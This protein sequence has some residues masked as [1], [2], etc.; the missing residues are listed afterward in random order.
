[1]NNND[2]DDKNAA[3]DSSQQLHEDGQID[4]SVDE[5]EG[6]STTSSSSVYCDQPPWGAAAAASEWKCTT[7]TRSAVVVHSLHQQPPF[8]AGGRRPLL[9]PPVRWP[10][11]AKRKQHARRPFGP[12]SVGP[13]LITSF[14]LLALICLSSVLNSFSG[15][16]PSSGRRVGRQNGVGV[17]RERPPSVDEDEFGKKHSQLIAT[18]AEA[19][20]AQRMHTLHHL[21]A[22]LDDV[23]ALTPP[24]PPRLINILLTEQQ[25]ARS[26]PGTPSPATMA[27]AAAASPQLLQH[28]QQND[29][30]S[31]STATSA[32]AINSNNYHNNQY[33]HHHLLQQHADDPTLMDYDAIDAYWRIDIEQEKNSIVHEYHHQLPPV[34]HQQQNQPTETEQQLLPPTTEWGDYH[35][36]YERDLQLLTEKSMFCLHQQQQPPPSMESAPAVEAVRNSNATYADVVDDDERYRRWSFDKMLPTSSNNDNED[37]D[38]WLD[39]FL[40]EDDG[41]VDD[42]VTS[43]GWAERWW[44]TVED[45]AAVSVAQGEEDE[46]RNDGEEEMKQ[47]SEQQQ[48]HHLRHRTKIGAVIDEEKRHHHQAFDDLQ[49]QEDMELYQ[50]GMPQSPSSSVD[51]LMKNVEEESNNNSNMADYNL[52]PPCSPFFSNFAA[53]PFCHQFEDSVLDDNEVEETE[54]TTNSATEAILRDMTATIP[55]IQNLN[56]AA[57]AN[58]EPSSLEQQ[59]GHQQNQNSLDVPCSSAS[60]VHFGTPSSSSGSKNWSPF[61][62]SAEHKYTSSVRCSSTTSS[63]FGSCIGFDDMPPSPSSSSCTLLGDE[64]DGANVSTTSILCQ[65][66]DDETNVVTTESASSSHSYRMEKLMPLSTGTVPKQKRRKMGQKKTKKLG[67]MM[68]K[69]AKCSKLEYE[70]ELE[71]L[72]QQQEDEE[73]ELHAVR[74]ISN[75]GSSE[76]K[77]K[78][79]R[80]RKSKDN[81]LVNEHGLPYTAELLTAMPYTA[82]SELMNDFRLSAPQK[83]MIKKIRRRGRNKL[84]AQK[85]RERRLHQPHGDWEEGWP[86]MEEDEEELL[87][88]DNAIEVEQIGSSDDIRRGDGLLNP[89]NLSLYPSTSTT[90][91]ASTDFAHFTAVTARTTTPSAAA[92]AVVGVGVVEDDHRR[93]QEYSEFVH[94]AIAKRRAIRVQV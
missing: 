92:A 28:Q 61:P 72:Q 77:P 52:L 18:K 90:T 35:R 81:S 34:Q 20:V 91:T 29:H 87:V 53:S 23:V 60:A 55:L 26:R 32:D 59:W 75:G 57:A 54:A 43:S 39:N 37:N 46:H 2:D 67:T 5:A 64:Y 63:G 38:E 13:S 44:K 12:K 27:A 7:S 50:S 17:R 25:R 22:N 8:S 45:F 83:A 86:I 68:K 66:V 4:D 78:S 30:H 31:P 1:M 80:G 3:G 73:E 9:L 89:A 94:S 15:L 93:R 74:S 47:F 10:M 76:P 48:Q 79:K 65:N 42:V 82:Y 70:R 33:H 19:V 41:V 24:S 84:A 40:Q 62:G 58:S 14:A 51:S 49:Q 11:V 56:F 88:D 69:T 16:K 21:L 71:Q 36:Q 6:S 85:C